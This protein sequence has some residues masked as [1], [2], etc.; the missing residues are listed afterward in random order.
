MTGP[1]EQTQSDPDPGEDLQLNLGRF[2]STLAQAVD[3][4]I[5]R[6]MASH[7]LLPM[8]VHLLVICQ[9]K[10]E[11]TATQ[12]T[13][14]LPVDA[15][16]ISRLVNGLVERG[17]VIRRRP[18]NDRRIVLLRLSPEG[19]ELTSEVSRRM[20]ELHAG[21]T[22]GLTERELRAFADVALRMIANH[23][24]MAGS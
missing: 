18:G 11:C 17:L 16:R 3:R 19:K 4:S 10:G 24:A 9:D 5:A 8:D 15:A 13:Q 6:T 1:P 22:E 21:L 2:V 7:D 12:L 20:Q 14:L 23:E